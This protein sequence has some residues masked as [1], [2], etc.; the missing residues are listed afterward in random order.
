MIRFKWMT[1]IGKKEKALKK[2]RIRESEKVKKTCM[3]FE[4]DFDNTFYPFIR[5]KKAFRNKES[6][7]CFC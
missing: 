5:C 7:N 3:F 6:F 1:P 2:K 4:S